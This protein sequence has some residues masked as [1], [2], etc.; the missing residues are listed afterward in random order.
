MDDRQTQ[1]QVGAGLQESRLNTDLINWLE[2]W[3]TWILLAILIVVGSYVGYT[4]Y[5]DYLQRKHDEAFDQYSAARGAL[6]ADGVLGGSPDNLLRIA[7]EMSSRQSIAALA[8]LDAAEIY[9]GSARRGLRPGVDLAN[10]KPEDALSQAETA[11]FVSKAATLFNEV[12]QSLGSDKNNAVLRLRAMWGQT[13]AAISNADMDKARSLLKEIET[14]ART[15]G[16]TQQADEAAARVASL[17][18]LAAPAV[19]LSDADLPAIAAPPP[20]AQSQQGMPITIQNPD[21]LQI[22]RMPEG[23]TPP[24]VAPPPGEAF[25]IPP[26]P[27]QSPAQ[28]A[29]TPPADPAPSTPPSEA[30]KPTP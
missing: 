28:P 7:T 29:Q 8:K 18:A 25:V 22:E 2:K 20:A 17:D 9:L 11:E 24:G 16:F 14:L 19:L 1:I 4:R 30:E 10:I 5:N 6:G 15:A 23:F 13:S 26:Q 12:R 27:Q 3:G 21:G